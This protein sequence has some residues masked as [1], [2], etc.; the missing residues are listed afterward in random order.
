MRDYPYTDKAHHKPNQENPTDDA[1]GTRAP[2]GGH[3]RRRHVRQVHRLCRSALLAHGR[4]CWKGGVFVA[5]TP[6]IWYFKDTDGDGKADV[7]RKVFTGFR[8]LNVQA[9]MNSLGLGPRQQ[10]L[11]RRRQQRRPDPPRAISPTRTAAH[12][13]AARDFRFDPVTEKFEAIT[14]GARFG[15]TFDDWGNRFLCNIRNPGAARRPAA[16]LPR[17]QSVPGR[18]AARIHDCAESG[19]QLPRLS[20]QPA[21]SRGAC[22]ARSA[23]RGERGINMPRSELVGAGVVDL[24]QR[25]HVY[26]GA[27]YPEQFPRQRLRRRSRRQPV[28]RANAHARR[29]RRSR[30]SAGRRE[31]RDSSLAATTGSA[32]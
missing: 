14:G 6:D 12:A 29:R 1:I 30:A 18:A 23:G 19:D 3:G 24:L 28:H 15:G 25:H 20:H 5:A 10:D 11:R 13:D 21:R 31:D 26:R 7:R 17:A 2:A 4:R 8:K 9:V 16:A 32:P 22:S 27:A